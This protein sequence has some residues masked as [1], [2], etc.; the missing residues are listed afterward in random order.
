[1][2]LF[3]DGIQ[4][5]QGSEPLRGDSLLFTIQMVNVKFSISHSRGPYQKKLI[6]TS[7]K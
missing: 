5:S 2:A 4:L 1:M 7:E 3:I 6:M